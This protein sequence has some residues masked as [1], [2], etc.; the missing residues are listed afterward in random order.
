MKRLN[1]ERQLLERKVKGVKP[2][3]PPILLYGVKF[4]WDG[5]EFVWWP[6][7]RELQGLYWLAARAE[8]HNGGQDLPE[9][10]QTVTLLG[11]GVLHPW[12]T[13]G[14]D[15]SRHDLCDVV[16]HIRTDFPSIEPPR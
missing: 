5:Q 16:D 14:H 2:G 4:T 7:T 9:F 1:Y 15:D 11:K 3:D 6:R 8:Q 13:V 10:E 12:S